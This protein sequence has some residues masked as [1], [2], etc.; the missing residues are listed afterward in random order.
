MTGSPRWRSPAAG[1]RRCWA[2]RG[3][4]HRRGLL[5]GGD[6]RRHRARRRR[7]PRQDRP[8][9]RRH[10]GAHGR[11]VESRKPVGMGT[12]RGPFGN[13]E[14]SSGAHD[15]E[16]RRGPG[17]RRRR[18]R[19]GDPA[20]ADELEVRERGAP[21]RSPGSTTA[22]GAWPT[23]RFPTLVPRQRRCC[24]RRT[25]GTTTGSCGTAGTSRDWV[26]DRRNAD[27][28]R[29]LAHRRVLGVAERRL[30]RV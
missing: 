30:S 12:G 17:R 7:L 2:H 24:T 26:G 14:R 18:T 23:T 19:S 5:A 11:H 22:A 1:P 20:A 6:G 28:R 27:C 3:H 9:D 13:V 8:R 4:E 25:T 10:P 21:R 15:G 29:H 16:P